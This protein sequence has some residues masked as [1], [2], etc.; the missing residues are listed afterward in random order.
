MKIFFSHGKE[1][2]PKGTKIQRMMAVA[3]ALNIETYS[4]DYRGIADPDQ[5][6]QKLLDILT[7]ETTEVVLV[8]SSMGG[9]VSTV[10]A[11]QSSPKGLFLLAPAFFMPDY[12]VQHFDN[13][14]SATTIVH[15]WSDTV[16]PYQHSVDFA[17]Q[18]ECTLHL[19]AS[20]HRL[21]DSIETVLFLFKQFLGGLNNRL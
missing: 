17:A 12:K 15:G 18:L 21:T 7:K 6:V 10:V 8:G 19:I 1:S 20:D 9:Y 4:V 16:I 13:I 2:G 3:T 11:Q 5:R 14:P